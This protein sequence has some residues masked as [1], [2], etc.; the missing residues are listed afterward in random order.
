MAGEHEAAAEDDV[1]DLTEEQEVQDTP[2]AEEPEDE[3]HLELEGEES[4]TDE[5]G[6]AKDLRQRNRDM[7]RELDG[8]RKQQAPKKVDVGARPTLDGCD[9]D[10]DKFA[11]ELESWH[12]RKRQNEQVET[13]A[14]EAE[15]VANEQLRRAET[16]YR[17]K[18]AAVPV[19]NYQDAENAVTAA[20]TPQ[21]QAAMISY[22]DDA[23]K[24]VVAL[25]KYPAMLA[26]VAAEPD[27]VRAL[28]MMKDMEK[29][30]K[31]DVVRKAP[32][33]PEAD[34]IQRGS[35]SMA[36]VPADKELAKLEKEAERTG[37][38]TKII[39]FKRAQKQ[40]DAK[41]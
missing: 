5:P 4:P 1:L 33:P 23:P 14:Q 26:K 36:S 37:D 24:I 19:K 38:R 22:L 8:Y 7:A 9:Y 10:E 11:T 31:T 28:M 12:D 3:F 6:W 18:A 2:P 32:P 40:K 41:K 21:L 25:H 17:A 35:G 30:I 20:L 39:A 29:R 16:S 27:A 15:R 34:T 13:K